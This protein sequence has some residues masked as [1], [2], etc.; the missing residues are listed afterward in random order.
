MDRPMAPPIPRLSVECFPL[1]GVAEFRIARHLLAALGSA[2]CTPAPS[3]SREMWF[4]G[5]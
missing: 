5:K 4:S 1:F 3:K 2:V